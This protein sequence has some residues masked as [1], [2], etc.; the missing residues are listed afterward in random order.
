MW[1]RRQVNIE[2]TLVQLIETRLNMAATLCAVCYLEYAA[3]L[4]DDRTLQGESFRLLYAVYLQIVILV[5]IRINF[6][7]M[8]TYL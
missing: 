1:C 5:L 4:F 2:E 8:A 6:L 3:Y 7:K